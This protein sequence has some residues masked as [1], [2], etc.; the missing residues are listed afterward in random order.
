MRKLTFFV[1]LTAC[2]YRDIKGVGV[3]ELAGAG[4]TTPFTLGLILQLKTELLIIM[5]SF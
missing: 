3:A 1:T 5:K 4:R 2:E